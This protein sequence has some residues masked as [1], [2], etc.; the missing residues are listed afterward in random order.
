MTVAREVEEW[1]DIV[2]GF[3]E[4]RI[5]DLLE[6]VSGEDELTHNGTFNMGR[7]VAYQ[8]MLRGLKQLKKRIEEGEKIV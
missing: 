4:R 6:S 8:D 1:L 2:I 7:A 3:L 5:G